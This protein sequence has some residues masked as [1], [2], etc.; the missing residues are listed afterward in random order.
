MTTWGWT[1]S[2]LALACVAV[3]L[4]GCA[5]PSGVDETNASDVVNVGVDTDHVAVSTTEVRLP[6]HVTNNTSRTQADVDLIVLGAMRT[7]LQNAG[8]DVDEGHDPTTGPDAFKLVPSVTLTHA[9][10]NVKAKVTL[11]VFSYPQLTLLG[12]IAKTVTTPESIP[13]TTA[14]NLVMSTAAKLATDTFIANF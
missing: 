1:R 4:A 5:A 8:I 9:S 12:S 6:A 13:A 11:A 2:G 10:G 7:E 3:S 14:E